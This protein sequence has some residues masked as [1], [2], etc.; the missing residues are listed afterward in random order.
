[1]G[2]VRRRASR[3]TGIYP[4][5][6]IELKENTVIIVLGASGDLA[7]KK[8]VRDLETPGV[9]TFANRFPSFLLYLVL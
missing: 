1:M 9:L 6:T 3:L 4:T 8:T 2:A 7:K 5:S